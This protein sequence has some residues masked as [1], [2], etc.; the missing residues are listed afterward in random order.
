MLTLVASIGACGSAPPSGDAPTIEGHPELSRADWL[1]SSRPSLR[2][3]TCTKGSRFRRCSELD[4]DRCEEHMIAALAICSAAY[5]TKLP[6]RIT[7]GA[8]N[9]EARNQLTG[10]MWHHAAIAIGPA[11]LDMLCLLTSK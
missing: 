11:E 9:L 1:A 8:A 6:E 5:R 2:H 4:R 3:E 10:C 7:A